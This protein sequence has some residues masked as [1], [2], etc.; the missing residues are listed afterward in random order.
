MSYANREN[1][2]IRSNEI[3]D[4]LEK[5]EQSFIDEN[6]EKEIEEITESRA[7][8]IEFYVPGKNQDIR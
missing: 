6:G 8:E 3:D 1:V 7:M 4:E 5:I 2:T